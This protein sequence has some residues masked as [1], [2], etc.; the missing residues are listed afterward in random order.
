MRSLSALDKRIMKI[1]LAPS[2]GKMTSRAIAK[3]LGVPATTIQRHRRKLENTIL[4]MSYSMELKKFGWHKVDF[5]V[6]TERGKTLAIA[7][8]LLKLDEVVYV[9]RSIGQQTIDLHV[10]AILEGNADILR[11]MEQMKGML[12]VR[13]VIWTEVVDDVGR[14]ASVP[15]H[16]IEKL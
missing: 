3:T 16:L 14:K 8:Q 4:T 10:H 15:I 12:G 5:L 13:D 9:G 11:I 6:A 7:K 1:L 2:N